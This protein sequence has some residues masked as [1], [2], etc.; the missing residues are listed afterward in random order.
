MR[1]IAI[2]LL[3]ALF[4]IASA[5]A[6][7]R[8]QTGEHADFTRVVI[9]IPRGIAWRLGRTG[10]GYTLRLP[11]DEGFVLE[12]FF[13]LIP[14][15]RVVAVSQDPDRGELRLRVDCRCHARAIVYR[16]D[17][18]VIDIHDGPAPAA[19]P[20]EQALPVETQF[21]VR[22]EPVNQGE[23]YQPGPDPV[24]PVITPR[25]QTARTVVNRPDTM[26][27]GD[28]ESDP[29]T[30]HTRVTDTDEALQMIAQ[31]LGLSLGRAMS[32]GLLQAG[33]SL[34][35]NE[36]ASTAQS[37]PGLAQA[38]A[39]LPGLDAR[40]S[41]DP[42]AVIDAAAPQTQMGKTC[43]PDSSFDIASWGNDSPPFLQLRQ[44]RSALITAADEFE[45]DALLALARLYVFLG[46]G[47]EA[48]QMLNLDDVQTRERVILRKVAR[49]IDDEPVSQDLFAGQVSCPSDVA[50]W[51]LLAQPA[52]PIDAEVDRTAVINA[53]RALPVHVQRP[54]APRLAEALLA[55]GAQ[56]T[57]LQ[58]LGRDHQT[59]SEDVSLQLAGAAL[60]DAL[61]EDIQAIERIKDVVRND[62]R[63][64]PEALTRFFVE[65]VRRQVRFS[66]EDFLLA[67]ALRF[68]NAGTQAAESLADAQFDAYL[69]EDRFED[70]R[71][72]L[73]MRSAGRTSQDIATKTSSARAGLF[74][75]VT[76]RLPDA[77]FL[78]FVWREDLGQEAVETQNAVAVRL[79]ALGFPERALV[80]LSGNANGNKGDQQDALRAQAIYDVSQQQMILDRSRQADI[81]DKSDNQATPMDWTASDGP[82]LQ[83]SRTLVESS[84]QSRETIR[85][86]LQAAPAP[87]EF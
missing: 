80:V 8:V 46:F 85:A 31:T 9:A 53:Y 12:Q 26:T 68:E 79:L 35:G 29:Q 33:V 41:V 49:L 43:L 58:I 78:E 24:L 37:E 82:S 19:S 5:A 20:F 50:L 74:Q 40:T 73:H 86:L 15:D 65:G 51:A 11:T 45:D 14:R 52:L 34:G 62:P 30:E 25:F 39:R 42:R 63:A 38:M 57:A 64:T 6:P 1:C 16:S 69:S 67:D 72:L 83:G 28:L 56:D 17:Y 54:I 47:R 23:R 21:E 10:Q 87:E 22:Q 48:L 81:I 60:S 44:T 70:A 59:E 77:A 3:L 27:S 71:G 66:D 61:G 2:I 75:Q 32:A 36:T 76:A 4:P 18:L 84:E 55:V 13:D 7:L